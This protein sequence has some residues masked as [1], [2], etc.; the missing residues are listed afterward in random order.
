MYLHD[1][2]LKCGVRLIGCDDR[3]NGLHWPKCPKVVDQRRAS[4]DDS[5][6]QEHYDRIELD[7]Y[8][9]RGDE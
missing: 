4:G 6:A 3:R 7:A 1:T 8:A 2:C 9:G 5:V